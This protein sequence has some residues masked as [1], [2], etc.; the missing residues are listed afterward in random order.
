MRLY[1]LAKLASGIKNC[2]LNEMKCQTMNN[3][4]LEELI[5]EETKRL[6][7]YAMPILES[8]QATDLQKQSFKKILYSFKN[9]ICVMLINEM[10]NNGKS[11][12]Q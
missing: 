10:S 11:S 4:Q 1:H 9:N 3:N 7:G 8:M 6:V 5:N 12:N 2:L